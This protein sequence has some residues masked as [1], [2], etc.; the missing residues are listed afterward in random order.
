YFSKFSIEQGNTG[1]GTKKELLAGIDKG[2]KGVKEWKSNIDKQR[3]DLKT[4]TAEKYRAAELKTLENLPS[5]KT[6]RDLAIKALASYKDRLYGNMGLV[7]SGSIKPEDNLIFQENGKQSFDI[8]AQQIN[9]YAKEKEKYLQRLKGYYEIDPETGQ[10]KLDDK[11]MPI[12]V[13]PTSGG[14]DQSLQDLHDRMGNPDFTEMTFGENGMG[15]ITFFKTKIDEETKTRVLD[16]DEDGKPQP[17]DNVQDMSVLAFNNKRNQTAEKLDLAAETEAAIGKGT[18]LGQIFEKMD[19]FGKMLGVVTDDMRNNPQLNRLLQ[20]AVAA[21]ASTTERQASIL[22][23]NGPEAGRSLVYN[24]MQEQEL[25]DEGIDLDE[26]IDYTYID[27]DPTSKTYGKE[28]TGKKSKYIKMKMSKNNQLVPVIDADD[29]LA[30]ERIAGSSFYSGLRKDITDG[31]TKKAEFQARTTNSTDLKKDEIDKQ[32]VG[33]VEFSKRLAQGGETAKRALEEMKQSGLYTLE[34]G[35]NQILSKSEVKK[36]QVDG[37]E[38]MA[39][40]YRVQTPSGPRDT[41]VYHTKSDGTP[42]GLQDR[43]SQTL[44]IMMTNPTETKDLFDTYVGQG[45]NFDETYDVK[46]FVKRDKV[47]SINIK[48][49]LDTKTGG[50]GSSSS[51][52]GDEIDL[53][54]DAADSASSWGSDNA[55]LASGIQSS[56]QQALLNSGQNLKSAPKVTSDGTTIKIT[57]VNSDGKTISVSGTVDNGAGIDAS[58]IST[59]TKAL[60]TEF[61]S[62]INSEQNY[63]SGKGKY[64]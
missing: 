46:N 52:L 7:Q 56:L 19:N 30:A 8:L 64:D 3:L 12:F 13:K 57:A 5:D 40:V 2:I 50:T 62:N 32:K 17:Y 23:D 48:L 38:R 44:A 55:V 20:D 9:G 4:K 54:A 35:Y 61:L 26:K 25:K 36:V 59:Q 39:E 27:T 28:L 1:V 31:G 21:A 49:S 58:T 60:L 34:K 22:S 18:P 51:T 6:S 53:A 41:Y 63:S 24:E 16:L 47:S 37:E 11:G 45:N 33:R 10:K 43:T 15:R 29:K 14:I 42:I